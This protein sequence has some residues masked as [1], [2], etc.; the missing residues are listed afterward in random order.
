MRLPTAILLALITSWTAPSQT[1]TISTLAGGGA[2]GAGYSGDD[3]PATSA[4]LNSRWGVAVDSA[5][6]LYI[7]DTNNNRIRKVSGGIIT[8]VAGNGTPGFSGDSGPA[9]S[10]QLSAPSGV[11]VDSAGNL[12]IADTNNNRIRKV[13]GGIITTVAGNGTLGFSGDGGPATSAQ[14]KEPYGVTV[15]S[16]G[17]LYIAEPYDNRIRKISGGIITTLAGNGTSG[18]SGD[19]GPATSAQLAFPVGIAVDTAGNLYI[20]DGGFV[21]KV[22]GGIITTVAGG[23][24][25][26]GD[27]GPATRAKL[28]ASGVAMDT[29]GNLYIA[30][31]GN[32]RI[33]KVSGGIITTIAGKGTLGFSGDGG[34]ATSAQLNVP[35]TVAMDT[36]GNVYIADYRNN[37]VRLLTR[38]VAPFINQNGVVPI[39]SPVTVIQAGSWVSIYGTDL[40][41]GTF[42][43]NGDF[44]TSL[45]ATSVTINSKP[46]YL[47]F[48]SPTQINLQAPDD[49]ATGTVM[50]LVTSSLGTA[51]ST[52]ILAL[53]GP[54]FSL[55]GDGKNVAGEIATPNGEGAY[56]G[57]SYDLVGPS[58]AFSFKT[59]SVKAGETLV[60]YGV[61]FGPTTSAVPAGRLYSG[62]S[63][64]SNPV[65]ITIG[66]VQT[67]VAFSGITE[68]GLYQ[69]N[70]TV[71][72]G[73]GSGDQPLQA[74]VNGV[75]TPTGVVVSVQ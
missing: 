24:I 69:F 22:S 61:G 70:L 48:V 16:A 1:Y 35:V 12:Y 3:G 58:G 27:G 43:W 36:A 2:P 15:D 31:Q 40:A 4:Q 62:S 53:Q 56:G 54:C 14:L 7:A 6:N 28:G 25:E 59:R 23:G 44:P 38:I 26:L 73:T 42:L 20:A 68:S 9:T 55:L 37:R 60:L 74:T 21:R 67:N 46:A 10:I 50:V 32:E 65:T 49:T 5:G 11:A 63:P 72:P 52:V 30:D 64:T 51:Q 39:Y 13:S 71:P 75:P 34:P 57:G 17:N 41:N 47:W 29:A 66:G 8:T 18:F 33:R 45:G 19:G